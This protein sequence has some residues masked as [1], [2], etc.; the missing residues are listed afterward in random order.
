MGESKLHWGTAIGEGSLE[1]ELQVGPFQ[2]GIVAG[3]E[4]LEIALAILVAL[5]LAQLHNKLSYT[6]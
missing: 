1:E 2:E 4:L 3:A 6:P 5:L